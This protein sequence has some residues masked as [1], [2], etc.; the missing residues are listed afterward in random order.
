MTF[1]CGVKGTHDGISQAGDCSPLQ[2][3]CLHMRHSATVQPQIGGALGVR[4][5]GQAAHDG[6][7]HVIDAQVETGQEDRGR[8]IAGRQHICKVLI[9]RKP[10]T[11]HLQKATR[12]F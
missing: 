12:S 2:Q 11:E 7:L 8:H 9:R 6:Q 3:P 5:V 1:L 10:H 4:E